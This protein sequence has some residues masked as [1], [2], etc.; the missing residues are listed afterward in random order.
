MNSSPKSDEAF[1]L[2]MADCSLAPNSFNHR[3]HLR[4]AYLH[5]EKAGEVDLA[6]ER[7]CKTIQHY[8]AH[9]GAPDKFHC[10]LTQ[11]CVK[12]VAHFKARAKDLTWEE[13]LIKFPGLEQNMLELLHQHYSPARLSSPKAKEVFC[14]P[15]LLPF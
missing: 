6:A 11:A 4:L 9:H 7:V 10:T 1:L 14:E 15:D 3:A 2:A 12:V 8:A 13:L 5:L